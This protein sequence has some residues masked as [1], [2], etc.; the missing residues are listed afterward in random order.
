MKLKIHESYRTIVAVCD[1]DLIGKKF[2]EGIRQIEIG[3]HFFNGE[4]KN[5]Q[6]IFKILQDFNMEDATFNIVGK[7]AVE[8]ALEAGIIAEHGIIEIDCVPVALGL[9]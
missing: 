7:E 6:E 8:T 2:V 9:F 4:E 1:S 5:K 3:E